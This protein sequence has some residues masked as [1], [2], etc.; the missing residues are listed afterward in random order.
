M[1]LNE[2]MNKY[3]AALFVKVTPDGTETVRGADA[4]SVMHLYMQLIGRQDY[5]T[6]R[7]YLS[8]QTMLPR[9]WGSGAVQCI[10][11]PDAEGGVIAM[12]MKYTGDAA[13]LAE[14]AKLMM[15]RWQEEFEW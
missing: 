12:F 10:M 11:F 4:E 13:G 3:G 9:L 1:N 15:H 6:L 7:G 14:R 8:G 2:F 5:E